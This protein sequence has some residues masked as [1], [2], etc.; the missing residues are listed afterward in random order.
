MKKKLYILC[1]LAALA[2]VGMADEVAGSVTGAE[3]GEMVVEEGKPFLYLQESDSLM[4]KGRGVVEPRIL[5]CVVS[6]EDRRKLTQLLAQVQK[7]TAEPPRLY[8]RIDPAYIV[9]FVFHFPDGKSVRLD[10]YS[11]RNAEYKG[12]LAFKYDWVLPADAYREYT[13]ILKRYIPPF[14]EW[15]TVSSKE[16]RKFMDV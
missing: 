12:A 9:R 2:F 1:M 7:N 5:S 16:L 13:K 10:A 15:K 14:L 6:D 3:P 8:P 11:I 4:I